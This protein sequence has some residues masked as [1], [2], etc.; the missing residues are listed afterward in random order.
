MRYDRWYRPV[1][2]MT[3][4]G[5]KRTTIRVADGTLHIKHG[6]A[7]GLDVPL[8]DVRSARRVDGRRCGWGVHTLGDIWVV[9]GSRDGM[10]E[11]T[12]DRPFTSGT[13]QRMM[14]WAEVR[15]LLISVTEPDAFIALLRQPT[16]SGS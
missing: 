9:N 13:V 16:Q 3:G 1:A 6:W 5:P 12:F 7:F 2:T 4:L 15:S 11:L 8:Q 14:K 10:V